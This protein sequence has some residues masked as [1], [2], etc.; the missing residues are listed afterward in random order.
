MEA[1]VLVFSATPVAEPVFPIPVRDIAPEILAITAQLTI[2]IANVP[3]IFADVAIQRTVSSYIPAQVFAISRQLTFI[4]ADRLPV[5]A[6]VSLAGAIAEVAAQ[7]LAISGQLTFIAADLTPVLANV[8][9]QSVVGPDIAAQVFAIT[10][11]PTFVVADFTSIFPEVVKS[12]AS[13][14]CPL[15]HPSGALGDFIRSHALEPMD[16]IGQLLTLNSL[17]C[18]AANHLTETIGEWRAAV[19]AAQA[20]SAQTAEPLHN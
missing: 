17:L 5:F 10:G 6:N 16:S 13:V 7:I 2:I 11:K 18:P 20:G 12:A 1:I 15:I 4:I 9:I 3:A 8:A 14:E 19:H